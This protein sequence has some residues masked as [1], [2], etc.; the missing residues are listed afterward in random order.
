LQP[1][2]DPGTAATSAGIAQRQADGSVV[3]DHALHAQL[4][5]GATVSVGSPPEPARSTGAGSDD[6]PVQ[7][8][9]SSPVPIDASPSNLTVQSEG[10]PPPIGAATKPEGGSPADLDE[11][12]KQLYRRIRTQLTAEL[13]IDRERAGL[14]VGLER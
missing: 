8:E 6:Y 14:G 12:A 11:L 7:R 1:A 5:S 2:Q 3:F 13:R 9:A 10:G 4:L